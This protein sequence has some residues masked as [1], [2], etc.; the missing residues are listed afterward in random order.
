M[1]SLR[2]E[3]AIGFGI[4][5]VLSLA[6]FLGIFGMARHL[7]DWGTLAP[8]FVPQSVAVTLMSALVPALIARAKL[9]GGV[10]P[11]LL[12]AAV[13]AVG[14][15][16]LGV[17]LTLLTNAAALPPIGWGAALGVKML[18]GGALG[19]LV[20]TLVLRRMIAA[21]VPLEDSPR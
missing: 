12:R 16:V 21:Y 3:A 13:F 20:T 10:R 6:F 14:G 18:Y 11:V 8:D 19:A 5:A 7:L 15:A 2:R 4:N 17:A 9:G 1:I